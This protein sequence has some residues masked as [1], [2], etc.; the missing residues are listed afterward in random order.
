MKDIRIGIF[1]GFRGISFYEVIENTPG[2]TVAA[3]ADGRESTRD[4]VK[5]VVKDTV[6]VCETYEEMV[7]V[8]LDAV[9]LANYFH[10]HAKYAIRAMEAGLDVI[11][12]T[13]AAPTLGECLDLVECC[14]RTGRKYM[15]AANCP[16]MVGPEELMRVY[17]S[18]ELGQVLYA[19]AEY[20]H[21]SH[22]TDPVKLEESRKM[23]SPNPRHWRKHLPGCYYN[24]H[25]L[26]VLM[27]A[28]KT[29]PVRVTAMDVYS[30]RDIFGNECG[31]K[32]LIAGIGLYEMDNGAIFRSTGCC[33][34]G[35]SG[36]W[37]RLTC[38][39]GT[40]ETTREHQ[41]RVILR[42]TGKGNTEYDPEH[43][44]TEEELKSG[45][46]GADA[47][48]CKQIT[49]YLSGAV[50]EPIFD[51]Y[52]G[53]A[54]SLAGIYGHYSV[55]EG[56]TLDIPDIRDKAAREVLRGDYRSPFVDENGKKTL[57]TTR[58]EKIDG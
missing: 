34:M 7:A 58:Y 45:H 46:G 48:I 49:D 41:D 26:G 31:Q 1:G 6:V 12:E 44:Y 33:K 27:A 54:L 4:E 39:K 13:T 52:R 40:I 23:L 14:E 20:L 43:Q 22:T 18:G 38:D 17:Q 50:A 2:F 37:Y 53:V 51:I 3:I 25:S 30:T 16:T 36:K 8:G 28:T 5:K 42:P 35:P 19:E 24:M 47:R 57:P 11:S 32:R 29:L 9:I 15:L 56:K 10:E 55:L 21:T